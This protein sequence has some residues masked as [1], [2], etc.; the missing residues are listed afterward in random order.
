MSIAASVKQ[1]IERLPSGR[2][3]G[4]EVFDD[5]QTAPDAVV[6]TVSRCVDEQRLKVSVEGSFLYAK[7]RRAWS[8][9]RK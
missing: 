8:H 7:T 2:I 1:T 6:R 4:Y 9:D 5:Y 3:F